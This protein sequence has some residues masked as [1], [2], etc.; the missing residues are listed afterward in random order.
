MSMAEFKAAEVVG[1]PSAK[2]SFK[3]AGYNN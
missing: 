2:K 1:I 3:P